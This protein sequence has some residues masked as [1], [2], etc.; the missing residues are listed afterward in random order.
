MEVSILVVCH[1][2]R[3]HI[4]F[5]AYTIEVETVK[6]KFRIYRASGLR[7]SSNILKEFIVVR[8]LY[9]WKVRWCPAN[10]VLC[11]EHWWRGEGIASLSL[12]LDIRWKWVVTYTPGERAPGT[13][14]IRGWNRP[15]HGPQRCGEKKNL[16]PCR[17][18]NYGCLVTILFICPGSEVWRSSVSIVHYMERCK[19]VGRG[20][21]LPT[22][23]WNESLGP[24]FDLCTS[25]FHSWK[26]VMIKTSF[27]EPTVWFNET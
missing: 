5:T 23:C 22:F 8:T 16:F 15:W 24:N 1:D 7:P 9:N 19:F 20:G 14:W 21:D 6:L 11:H 2:L 27:L 10:Q 4:T 26:M 18:L 17:E 3:C 13:H 12:N 25:K